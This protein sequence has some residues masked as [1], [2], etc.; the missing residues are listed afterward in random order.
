MNI[1]KKEM[2]ESDK[3]WYREYE[4]IYGCKSAWSKKLTLLMIKQHYMAE[5]LELEGYNR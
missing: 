4:K 1:F 3:Y 2:S 5:I